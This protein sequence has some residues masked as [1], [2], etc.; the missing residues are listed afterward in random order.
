MRRLP[1]IN[2]IAYLTPS[3]IDQYFP[4]STLN[5][6]NKES[7]Q[8]NQHNDEEGNDDAHRTRTNQLEQTANCIRQACCNSAKNEYRNTI[9]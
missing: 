9:S 1:T 4:L 3:V 6:Y 8:R 7:D 2:L 5:K